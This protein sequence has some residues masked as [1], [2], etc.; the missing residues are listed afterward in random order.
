MI[1]CVRNWHSIHQEESSLQLA[2]SHS[3]M[4]DTHSHDS[5]QEEKGGE[6]GREGSF[7]HQAHFILMCCMC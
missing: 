7:I 3:D 1:R 6:R 5:T 2:H 4:K